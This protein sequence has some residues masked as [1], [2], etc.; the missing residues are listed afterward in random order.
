MK[1]PNISYVSINPYNRLIY[2]YDNGQLKKYNFSKKSKKNFY[3][4][5]LNRKDFILTK[6]EIS[7]NIPDEDL[8]DV[9]E[10]KTY[11]ELDLDQTVEYKIEYME[12]P[13]LPTDKNRI[14]QVFVTEPK[15]IEETFKDIISKVP[16]IDY[17]IPV[18]L[19]F[20]TLYTNEL[21]PNDE[22]HL[23]LYM[24][25]DDT[26]LTLYQ[27]GNLLYSKSLKYSFKDIAQRLSEL[28]MKEVS[29]EEVVK[30]LSTEGLKMSDL[31]RLQYYMQIFSELFMHIN[32]VLIYAKRAN[33]IEVIDKIFID[34]EFGFIKG[35]EEYSLTYLAQEAYDFNF[36]F[37][38]STNEQF[39]EK[40]HFL[41]ILTAKDI[42]E[43]EID[44]PNFTLYPRPKPL[45]KRPTGELLLI[46]AA[47]LLIGAAYPAY[48]FFMGYKYR[49]ESLMLQKKYEKVHRK[50]VILE[51]NINRLK[52]EIEELKK[53]IDNKRQELAKSEKVLKSIYDKKVNY[54][55]KAKTLADLSQD[56]V[57]YKLLV[58]QIDVN[59]SNF[60]FNVTSVDDKAITE[61]IKYIMHSKNDRYDISIKSIEKPDENS[62]VYFSNLKVEVK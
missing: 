47:S 49:Y 41:L 40:I 60:D 57:N 12:L 52:K 16:F 45:F 6:L 11:E 34:S 23:F 50:R 25:T 42:K 5:F 18:P 32:D 7:K 4:S 46:T 20:K 56:L 10:L 43:L 53:K 3:I 61:F 51:T 31:E 22:V 37:P 59:N 17:I 1:Q 14:F 44:Y 8:R 24:Q 9:I 33:N 62:S 36:D 29:V 39:V 58:S 26:F 38:I 13:T 55:L 35:I 27:N 21:L 28:M 30:D 54:I 19:V 2:I 48:N 15:I